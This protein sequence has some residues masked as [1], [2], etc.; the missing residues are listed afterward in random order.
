MMKIEVLH[1]GA[2]SNCL[3]DLPA[4]RNAAAAVDPEVDWRELDIVQA[5]DYAVELGVLKPP[6]IA[7]D[8]R[9]A[10]RFLP[11]AEELAAAMRSLRAG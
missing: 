7:I 5:I 9:L 1:A 8:G 3:K 11:E 4:L 10:F 2:C 6:A